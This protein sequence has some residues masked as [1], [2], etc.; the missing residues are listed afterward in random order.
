MQIACPRIA[1]GPVRIAPTLFVWAGFSSD[2]RPHCLSAYDVTNVTNS[3][4]KLLNP[5]QFV[6]ASVRTP[7]PRPFCIQ[8]HNESQRTSS[9]NPALQRVL[10]AG[11]RVT[12]KPQ[13]VMVSSLWAGKLFSVLAHCM[14]LEVSSKSQCQLISPAAGSFLPCFFP[15]PVLVAYKCMYRKMALNLNLVLFVRSIK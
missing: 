15:L 8:N 9:E 7:H 2:S 14:P 1:P 13:Y 6:P 12:E 4:N 11:S 10:I 5:Q 3:S